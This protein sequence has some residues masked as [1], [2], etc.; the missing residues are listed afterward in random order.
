MPVEKSPKAV[1]PMTVIE[2]RVIIAMVGLPAR[3]KSYTSKAIIHYLTFLGCPVRLFNAG[4]KRRALGL[5]G[6]EAS[7]FDPQNTDAKVQ[8]EQMAM[9]TLDDLLV[10]LM[11][12][13][14][15][16]AL[17]IFDATNTTMARRRAVIER[18]ARAESESGMSLRLVFVE[19]VCNDPTILQQS[20]Q[21]K[22]SNNDYQGAN[23]EKALADFMER[24]REYE[25]VY[26]T[27]DDDEAQVR[28]RMH[29]HM[30]HAHM[31]YEPCT[32]TCVHGRSTCSEGFIYHAPAR[33]YMNVA[34]APRC[35]RLSST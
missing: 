20:Y 14:L 4:N 29:A 34:R 32:C 12:P 26:E 16:C 2:E 24:V 17:G 1:N 23:P 22:L 15:G 5:A 25:K 11:E 27:I 30:R 28:A 6:A 31:T 21:M 18:A 3:G 9:D 33:A 8:R 10:W 7:F 19:S 35:L 13:R